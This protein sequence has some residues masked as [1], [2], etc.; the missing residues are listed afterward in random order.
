MFI[1]YISN[2]MLNIDFDLKRGGGGIRL[3]R[4]PRGCELFIGE[5]ALHH[6]ALFAHTHTVQKYSC[7]T[8]NYMRGF[9][10]ICSF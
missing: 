5:T 7:F 10:S 2:C 4:G 1:F 6:P 8:S 3:S 9:I